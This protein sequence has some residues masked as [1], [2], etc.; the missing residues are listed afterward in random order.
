MHL[1]Q[2]PSLTQT[3]ILV[4]QETFL[5]ADTYITIPGKIIYRQDRKESSG[6]GLLV[7]VN[8]SFPSTRLSIAVNNTHAEIMGVQVILNSTTLNIL[9]VYSRAGIITA[10]LDIAS[11]DLSGPSVILGDFNLHHPVWG[12]RHSSQSSE[13]FVEWLTASRFCISSTHRQ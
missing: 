6:G 4:L 5:K 8:S 11:N 2:C 10:D 12:A 3:D 1:L 13:T 7:A 9:N